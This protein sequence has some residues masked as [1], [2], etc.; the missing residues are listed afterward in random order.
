[1]KEH[2]LEQQKEEHIAQIELEDKENE[3][4]NLLSSE[5]K[6]KLSSKNKSGN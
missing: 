4:N 5:D 2:I 3:S 6:L 1:M